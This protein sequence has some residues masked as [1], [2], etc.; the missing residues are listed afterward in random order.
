MNKTNEY[1][2]CMGNYKSAIIG[3]TIF[4]I[5]V[6][7][8][9]GYHCSKHPRLGNYRLSAATKPMGPSVR[10][11]DKMLHPYWGNCNKCHI[12]LN[13][14]RPVSQVMTGPPISIK[15][16]MLHK[17]WGNCLLCHKVTDGF[18]AP[19]A[20]ARA[21]AFNQYTAQDL[22]LNLKAVNAS[23]MV[24]LGLSNE[25]GLFILGVVQNS[26]AD[27]AGLKQS[28]EII[29]IGKVRVKTIDDCNR[30]LNTYKPGSTIKLT[31]DRNNNRRNIYLRLNGIVSGKTAA[32]PPTSPTAPMTQN[33]IETLAEQLG[34]PKTA[35]AVTQALQ[36][37]QNATLVA[38]KPPM[39]QNQIETLAEQLGVPKTAQA[40]T[41]ALQAQQNATLVAATPPMTQNQI[42]TLA[43]QL[44][45]PKTAQAVT[46]ALQAQQQGKVVA[47]LNFG[48]VAVAS[49]GAGIA[50]PV[51]PQFEISLYFV[52][53]DPVNN[54]YTVVA[55]PNA[56]DPR[57]QGI[58]TGQYMVD[59]DVSSVMA[60][61]YSRKALTT[62]H[63]LRVNVYSG[64]TGS[65]QD[66]LNTY[67]TGG[68]IP[69]NTNHINTNHTLTGTPAQAV[70]PAAG[71]VGL[72]AQGIY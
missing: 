21:A 58:Q 36:A 28:D 18:Q 5:M 1:E 52:V 56:N 69:L 22:G 63:G 49:T 43:E 14:G 53:F 41:Q 45:V 66:V 30:E 65:V 48:K 50:Y 71:A 54:S 23:T 35:Q 16:K 33:Q 4:L 62:L 61:S 20:R 2:F 3:I 6:L 67:L 8:W 64:L 17:Y 12:T 68:L 10:I 11:N 19:K 70:N 27:L 47:N 25:A 57:G 37:Q 24:G 13:P 31:I 60:G 32:N 39:T 55:N 26:I 15:D 72:N 42:E 7:A 38:A 46:Q 29:R 40:V 51:S 59:L 44:G 34:V 9:T